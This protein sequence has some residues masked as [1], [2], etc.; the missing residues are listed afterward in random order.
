MATGTEHI[1]RRDLLK[2]G[3]AVSA[4]ATMAMPSP[5]AFAGGSD[6]LGVA[7]IG[8]GSRGT[9]DALDFLQSDESVDLVAMAELFQDRLDGSLANLKQKFGK[10]V[11]VTPETSFLGFD[12]YK[13]VMAMKEVDVVLLL[14]PPGF[15]PQ[16]V[17][18]AIEAGKH[19]FMEKPG[20][21]DPVG[22]RS[23]MESHEMADRK[24]LSIVV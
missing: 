22:I 12:A 23:L 7:M 24:K 11:K 8:C 3:V 19:I 9:K 4:A 20:A 1:S 16:M 6:K 17:R 15:R 10:R 13:K 21:V 14:T 2:T 5:K 18:A